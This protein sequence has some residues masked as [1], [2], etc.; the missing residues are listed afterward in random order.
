MRRRGILAGSVGAVG[1]CA[2]GGGLSWAVYGWVDPILQGGAGWLEGFPSLRASVVLVGAGAGLAIGCL[3]ALRLRGHEVAGV[4]T[5]LVLSIVPFLTPL[6]VLAG[7]LGWKAALVAGIVLVAAVVTGVRLLLTRGGDDHP[8][9]PSPPTPAAT[10]VGRGSE[11]A[12]DTSEQQQVAAR[13][14]PDP[15]EQH[16]QR[17]APDREPDP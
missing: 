15:R 8:A 11:L 12:P 17:D 10:V 2:V 13:A 3:G 5:V 1:G 6:V 9:A 7:R 4:T 14:V 16:R